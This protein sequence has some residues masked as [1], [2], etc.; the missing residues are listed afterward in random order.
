MVNSMTAFARQSAEGEWGRATWELR[1]VNHRFLDL[2]LRLPEDFRAL[3]SR[4]RESASRR[5]K[6]G[7]VDCTLRVEAPLAGAAGLQVNAAVV[8]Q[9]AAATA[10]VSARLPAAAPVNP[11]DVLRFPGVLDSTTTD[12]EQLTGSVLA[13]FDTAI[14]SLAATR[15]REGA[16]LHEM[17]ASRTALAREQVAQLRPRMPAL[18]DEIRERLRTRLGELQAELDPT[19][20]EQEL[21]V[22]AS[23]LDVA[24]ELDRLDAHLEEVERVLGDDDAIG[25]RL[26]FLMQELHREANT[27]GAKSAHLATTAASVELKV[28]IE[29]MREQVQNI[30]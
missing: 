15:V 23:K 1:S 25:R 18:F 13:L 27:L 28:L 7:K 16:K 3:E 19:R 20:L 2:S 22:V 26:D 4:I 24:E 29:Q 30:E 5:L 21:V 17:I 8:D 9:I 11:L 6:R 14:E 12:A 10:A